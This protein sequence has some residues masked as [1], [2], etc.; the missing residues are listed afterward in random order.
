MLWNFVAKNHIHRH[1]ILSFFFFTLTSP[2]KMKDIAKG[3]T[4]P[5]VV[6][7]CQKYCFKMYNKL[8]RTNFKLY[9]PWCVKAMMTMI[10][11][12]WSDW[13]RRWHRKQ[14]TQEMHSADSPLARLF[15]FVFVFVLVFVVH[16]MFGMT[17]WCRNESV[18]WSLFW[19]RS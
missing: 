3:T 17:M 16:T 8:K 18:L 5:R 2:L 7:F 15:I 12:K 1:L 11:N 10:S 13:G 14:S 6:C 9:L 19:N 4:Y